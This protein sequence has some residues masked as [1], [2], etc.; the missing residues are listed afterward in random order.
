MTLTEYHVAPP[1]LNRFSGLVDPLP[2]KDETYPNPRDWL[3]A[4]IQRYYFTDQQIIDAAQPKFS[5]PEVP[6][7]T[8][9]TGLYFLILDRKIVYV[10]LAKDVGMRLEQHRKA[11]MPFDSLTWL[12]VPELF[13][14]D[15][16]AYY[17]DRIKPPL[18]IFKPL[19]Y[20]FGKMVGEYLANDR[21][22]AE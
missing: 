6:D 18:N 22:G 4:N 16:E 17:I 10:G 12:E 9:A 3:R 5:A 15:M 8:Y 21:K 14:K 20:Y 13:I 7:F 11:R 1:I 19:T 2:P